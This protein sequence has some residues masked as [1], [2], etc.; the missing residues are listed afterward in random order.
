MPVPGLYAAGEATGVAGINGSYGGSGTFLGPS[1]YTGRIAGRA[2]AQASAAVAASDPGEV[3]AAVAVRATDAD[4]PML[5][6]ADLSELLANSR[7]G[8]WHF[9]QA[10]AL[11]R[12][13]GWDCTDCHSTDWPTGPAVTTQQKRAQL[14]SCARCH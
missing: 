9:E 2:A 6:A 4:G 1:V 7:P 10:H 12:E 8:Y 14:E 3:S 13:R 5:K 11:V